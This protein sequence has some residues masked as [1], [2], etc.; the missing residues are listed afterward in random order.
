M[1][2]AKVI[3]IL[4]GPQA[5]VLSIM[6]SLKLGNES[7]SNARAVARL[8]DESGLSEQS[9]FLFLHF[10]SH[11][12]LDRHFWKE[13]VN[14]R[15]RTGCSSSNGLDE[16][17]DFRHDIYTVKT[18]S[19]AALERRRDILSVFSLAFPAIARCGRFRPVVVGV[20]LGSRVLYVT[21]M[22][23]RKKQLPVNSDT[24]D[25]DKSRSIRSG[26]GKLHQNRRV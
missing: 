17:G 22:V 5:P 15:L 7:L 24:A 25:A 2:I 23:V 4:L 16:S 26:C 13:L 21:G 8:R 19:K 11:L 9:A 6:E 18:V 3:I 14:V 12:D 1:S 10:V 20:F